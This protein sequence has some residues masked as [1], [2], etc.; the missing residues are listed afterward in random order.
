MELLKSDHAL[1]R[2][3]DKKDRQNKLSYQIMEKNTELDGE[4]SEEIEVQEDE[5]ALECVS[6]YTD[7]TNEYEFT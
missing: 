7:L 6:V 5:V 4:V 2:P 1:I 3:E